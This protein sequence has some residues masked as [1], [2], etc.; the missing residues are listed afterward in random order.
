MISEAQKQQAGQSTVIELS[1][2]LGNKKT[3][4]ALKQPQQQ[5]PQS[6]SLRQGATTLR[7]RRVQPASEADG[8]D[9]GDNGVSDHE[10]STAE[11]SGNKL[12]HTSWRCTLRDGGDQ[13]VFTAPT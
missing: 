10:N 2:L 8:V 6:A 4:S 7:Q 12:Q 9:T 1:E 11:G 5:R 3:R 13:V